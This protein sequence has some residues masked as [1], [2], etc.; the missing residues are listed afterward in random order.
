MQMGNT[1]GQAERLPAIGYYQR[2]I[3]LE[4]EVEHH[5]PR[6]PGRGMG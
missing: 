5:E 1:G 6:D 4:S 2:I 3:N